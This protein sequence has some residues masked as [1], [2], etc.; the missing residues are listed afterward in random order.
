MLIILIAPVIT[1]ISPAA[2]TGGRVTISGSNFG[3]QGTIANVT[4]NDQDC[5]GPQLTESSIVCNAAAGSG[6]GLDVVVEVGGQSTTAPLFSY[7]GKLIAKHRR[8]W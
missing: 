6:A 5:T 3:P 8:K 1:L 7:N 4:I 2:T